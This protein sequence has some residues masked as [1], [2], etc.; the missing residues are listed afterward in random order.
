MGAACRIGAA[1]GNLKRRE[2]DDVGDGVLLECPLQKGE[3]GDVAVDG[4][5]LR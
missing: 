3:V 5:D 2:V 1:K 4:P